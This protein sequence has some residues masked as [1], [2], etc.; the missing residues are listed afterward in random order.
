MG[1]AAVNAIVSGK[2]GVMV[3]TSDDE[4]TL[5]PLVEAIQSYRPVPDSLLNLLTQVQL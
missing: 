1:A 4:T 5:T 2:T 3:G